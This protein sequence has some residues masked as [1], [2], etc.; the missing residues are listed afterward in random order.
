ML[1]IASCNASSKSAMAAPPLRSASPVNSRLDFICPFL[2]WFPGSR[3]GEFR[4]GQHGIE[5]VRILE[6]RIR[7]RRP[8]L[9]PTGVAAQFAQRIGGAASDPDRPRPP[10]PPPPAGG[11]GRGGVGGGGGGARARPAPP[12]PP[13]AGRASWPAS[14][15]L[16]HGL[17]NSPPH[18]GSAACLH[19]RPAAPDE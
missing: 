4:S 17:E 6:G 10:P 1:R 3:P 11:G 9:Q 5:V 19:L 18:P 14:V 15:F 2:L 7:F 16:C 12:A 13:A 8:R